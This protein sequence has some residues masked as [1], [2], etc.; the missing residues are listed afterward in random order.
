MIKCPKCKSHM[1]EG[2]LDFSDSSFVSDGKQARESYR[3]SVSSSEN[4]ITPFDG[5]DIMVNPFET[6]Q[7]FIV[8]SLPPEAS[9]LPSGLQLT[10]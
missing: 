8:P 2:D 3:Q 10:A 7:I 9:L 6:S 1:I 4:S 5:I